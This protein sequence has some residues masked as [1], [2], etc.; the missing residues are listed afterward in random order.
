MEN[1]HKIKSELLIQKEVKNTSEKLVKD[2]T[3]NRLLESIADGVVVINNYERIV[4]I[5]TQFEKLFGY[6]RSELIGE[7]IS[8]FLDPSVKN[9]HSKHIN[10]FF[11]NPQL[12]PMGS[13]LDLWGITKTKVK[14]PI[15][16]SLSFFDS[17]YGKL[18]L[19]FVSDISIRKKAEM[20]LIEKNKQ[21]DEFAGIIA[22][23]LKNNLNNIVGF[24]TLLKQQTDT[25]SEEEFETIITQIN[26]NA[27]KMSDIIRELLIFARL[28]HQEV[29]LYKLNMK[30]ILDE[31]IERNRKV[32]DEYNIELQIGNVDNYVLGYAPWL[33]EV[34]YNL[35]NNSAVYGGENCKV[36][37]D[38]SEN[39]NYIEY[40]IEDNGPGIDPKFHKVLFED[41]S[42]IKME[43]VKGNGIGLPIVKKIV[44]KIY[45]KISIESSP[46]N[47]TKFIIQLQK[48]N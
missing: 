39:K 48:A 4:F 22:H 23:D 45:G 1:K 27:N 21:L 26:R 8:I 33:E 43:V 7:T 14:I 38:S 24:S 3:I 30:E 16:V 9:K 36:K 6:K 47:G 28:K 2:K 34:W 5:N 40:F 32:I 17:D 44:D 18:G 46:G 25:F 15:E 35:I 11:S 20:E 42:K 31:A 19:A 12:R 37:I 29:K 41:N 10:D 13:G